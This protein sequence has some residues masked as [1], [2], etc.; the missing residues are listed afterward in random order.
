[1]VFQGQLVEPAVCFSDLC[2]CKELTHSLLD[3]SQTSCLLLRQQTFF[4]EQN[5]QFMIF[6]LV[7]DHFIV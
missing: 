7:N 5:F 4:N 6:T 3:R 2:A 1:M